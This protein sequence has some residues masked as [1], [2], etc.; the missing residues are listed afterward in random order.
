[1]VFDLKIGRLSAAQ[2]GKEHF[3]LLDGLR[4]VAAALVV[5]YHFGEWSNLPLVS[6]GYLA[7]DFF[8]MLS[9]FVIAFAYDELLRRREIGLLEFIKRRIIRLYPLVILGAFVGFV[10]AFG[11]Q[12]ERHYLGGASRALLSLP[13]AMA[14]LPSPLGYMPFEL[15]IP[16]WSLFFELLANLA[17]A[18][19]AARVSG[20]YLLVLLG[21]SFLVL[22]AQ[23]GVSGGLSPAWKW[24]LL[25]SGFIRVAFPYLAG[26]C[27]YRYRQNLRFAART[28]PGWSLPLLL[29]AAASTPEFEGW[30]ESAYCL[31][32]IG[33]LFPLIIVV[34]A[35]VTVPTPLKGAM[36][37][38]GEISFPLY[39]LHY[40]ICNL[41]Y[42]SLPAFI[43]PLVRIGLL[44]AFIGLTAHL[45]FRLY[46]RPIRGR[47]RSLLAPQVA[48]AE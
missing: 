18:T 43:S 32:A 10:I 48:L 17:Y 22:A 25:P 31:L 24:D 4:G 42:A 37:W 34:G 36:A 16:S 20:K 15:N 45:A 11:H 9:G 29:V 47:I 27:I 21:V 3:A 1:M 6:H 44:T 26:L 23:T 33:L 8:W 7:V 14:A 2:S 13:F 46:D 40:P 12:L 28:L 38:A 30:A 39:I 35:A 41:L 5:I 19:F